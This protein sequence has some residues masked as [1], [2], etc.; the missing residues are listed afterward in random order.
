MPNGTTTQTPT[1][2][3]PATAP[4]KLSNL[5]GMNTHQDDPVT[6][7]KNVAKE[8]GGYKMLSKALKATV[9]VDD[10]IDA[11][12]GK[13]RMLERKENNI[14]WRIA[15]RVRS[16]FNLGGSNRSLVNEINNVVTEILEICEDNDIEI[17]IL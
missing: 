4:K 15:R 14:Y 5:L 16:R 2:S 17:D 6:L 10:N 12:D 9:K 1:S 7:I 11:S 13:Y 8:F 3:A